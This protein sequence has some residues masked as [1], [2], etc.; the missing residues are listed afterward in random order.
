MYLLELE[1]IAIC[2]KQEVDLLCFGR[3]PELYIVV[4]SRDIH[5]YFFILTICK[6]FN[7]HLNRK[8]N[9]IERMKGKLCADI[10]F[11]SIDV[12]S[13]QTFIQFLK[14]VYVSQLKLPK[15]FQSI[16]L[17]SNVVMLSFNTD[18]E[19]V[20]S[21][22][23]EVGKNLIICFVWMTADSI[24]AKTFARQLFTGFATNTLK[25]IFKRRRFPLVAV[26]LYQ[27]RWFPIHPRNSCTEYLHS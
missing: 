10:Q 4:L 18:R 1:Y 20:L 27:L 7:G 21:M 17:P 26:L 16:K 24:P 2:E 23:E 12:P 6:T 22:L 13:K 3:I 19:T 8:Q 9:I 14:I 11:L 5:H 15:I 25:K